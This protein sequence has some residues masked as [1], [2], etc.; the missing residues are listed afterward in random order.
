MMLNLSADCR[1]Q[2][3]VLAEADAGQRGRDGAELAADLGRGVRLGVEGVDVARAALHPHQDA[4]RRRVAPRR[5]HSRLLQ[6]Q[7][8]GQS[9]AEGRQA[10]DTQKVAA[11]RAGAIDGV[12]RSEVEHRKTP[13]RT[14]AAGA[15]AG[16]RIDRLCYIA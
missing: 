8:G 3:Q 5:L 15:L 9:Q 11:G 10:A 6:A 12:T 14:I 1:Q 16:R 13:E 4:T 2:R 7:E